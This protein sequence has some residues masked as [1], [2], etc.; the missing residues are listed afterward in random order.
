MK[1]VLCVV[2]IFNPI[3]Q[4]V[5]GEGDGRDVK[6]S[7]VGYILTA[8]QTPRPA[9]A[10]TTPGVMPAGDGGTRRKTSSIFNLQRSPSTNN[11]NPTF[12]NNTNGGRD[13]SRVIATVLP[14]GGM[15]EIGSGGT[16]LA[17]DDED[18]GE[19]DYVTGSGYNET[20]SV[21]HAQ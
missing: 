7:V 18:Y 2:I 3:P 13:G 20:G 19:T 15:E 9:S 10:L 21:L 4:T 6:V 8:P 12:G 5:I 17:T 14:F 11:Q 16:S 1:L